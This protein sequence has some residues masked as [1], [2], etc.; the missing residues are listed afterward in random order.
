[1]NLLYL[2]LCIIGGTGLLLFIPFKGARSFSL[3]RPVKRVHE[4]DVVLSR[5]LLI[6]DTESFDSYYK[7]HPEFLEADERSRRA[8]GL[9]DHRSRY[10]HTGTYAAAEANFEVIEYLGSLTH[11]INPAQSKSPDSHSENPVKVNPDR[12]ARFISNWLK[13]TGALDVGFTRLQEYHLY[14]NKGRGPKSGSPILSARCPNHTE[15]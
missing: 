12:T 9:L 15:T 4:A 7:L 6:P 3:S 5:R 13:Q 1:M 2:V 8:P 11:G 14:S 10:F